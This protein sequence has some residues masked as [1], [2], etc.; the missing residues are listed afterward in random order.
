M[1]TSSQSILI[2]MD[3]FLLVKNFSIAQ[4]FVRFGNVAEKRLS[5][6]A[7]PVIRIHVIK[8]RPFLK[9]LLKHVQH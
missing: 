8:L 3:V 6:I 2:V 4:T 7:Q 5:T 1:L 9:L